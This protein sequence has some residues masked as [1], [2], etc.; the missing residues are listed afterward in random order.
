MVRDNAHVIVVGNEK[1]GSG[2]STTAFHLA[3][4]LLYAGYRV[5]TIDVDGRQQTLTHYVRNRRAHTRDT[6]R[7]AAAML[8]QPE[9][10]TALAAA[11]IRP[12]LI[13]R[14]S[15]QPPA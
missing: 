14:D 10:S 15:T 7:I 4:Y 3:I 9:G 8:L 12:H 13:V 2:K 1:G 6:G 11:S 5:A